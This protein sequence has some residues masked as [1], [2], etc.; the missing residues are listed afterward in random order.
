M[1]AVAPIEER[2]RWESVGEIEDLPDLEAR[3]A[4]QLY[5]GEL[6]AVPILLETLGA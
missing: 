4:P 3:S 1:P 6:R 5:K 2:Y